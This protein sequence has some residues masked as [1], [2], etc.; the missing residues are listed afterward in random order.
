MG[1]DVKGAQEVS[2]TV[3]SRRGGNGLKGD[4]WERRWSHGIGNQEVPSQG[5]G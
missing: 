4:F 5:P 3:L 2:P 1:Y